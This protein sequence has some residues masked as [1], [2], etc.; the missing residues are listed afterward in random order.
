MTAETNTSMHASAVRVGDRAVLIR[1]PSGSGKSRLA[2]DLLLARVSGALRSAFLFLRGGAHQMHDLGSATRNGGCHRK[3]APVRK[4]HAV[5]GH[6][7]FAKWGKV[8]VGVRHSS[9]HGRYVVD[10]YDVTGGNA[11]CGNY[12]LIECINCF[13]DLPMHR[14]SGM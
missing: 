12:R 5:K 4:S 13:N 11:A 6:F 10:F 3:P 14:V 8:P 7:I 1:G 9:P 2:F